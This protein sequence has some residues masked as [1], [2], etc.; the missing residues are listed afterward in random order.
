MVPFYT[1]R[2]CVYTIY[3]YIYIYIYICIYVYTCICVCI[4]ICMYIC[5]S[6]LC[7]YVSMFTCK[8]SSH[9]DNGIPRTGRIR[10]DVKRRTWSALCT[11]ASI[12]CVCNL[13]TLYICNVYVL[14]I[15]VIWGVW[16]DE[17]SMHVWCVYVIYVH[18]MYVMCVC[19]LHT[20]DARC[21]YVWACSCK[22]THHSKVWLISLRLE[23]RSCCI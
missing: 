19:L 9:L 23:N 7:V 21:V 13:C 12:K 20:Y 6:I 22:Q 1:V 14:Y 3:I 5:A 16:K 4:C 11:Y 2:R 10:V 15:R 17:P 18:Y 8:S